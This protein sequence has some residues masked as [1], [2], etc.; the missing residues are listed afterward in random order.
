MQNN[1]IERKTQ[2][3]EWAADVQ[4]VACDRDKAA[5]NRLFQHFG[6]KLKSYALML[7]SSH[8][9]P[10]MA[11]ELV[12]EVMLKIWLKAHWFNPEKA[13]ASTWIFTVARNC[14]IDFIRKANR[15]NTLLNAEDLWPLGEDDD[16]PY[17]SLQ[18]RRIEKTIHGALTELPEEQAQILKHV[19]LEGQ[20]HSEVSAATGIPLGTVKSRVRLAMKKL[21]ILVD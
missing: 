2:P 1:A 4:K 13:S 17:T 3:D 19:Y 7:R 11:E 18:Q 21:K 8:T 12:Q 10:E 14:R 20:S 16:E 5:F 9:S 15:T 6:P